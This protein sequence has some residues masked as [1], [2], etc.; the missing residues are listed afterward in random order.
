MRCSCKLE[1]LL[2]RIHFIFCFKNDRCNQRGVHLLDLEKETCL[3]PVDSQDAGRLN[4]LT[5]NFV[6]ECFY[7]AHRSFHLGFRVTVDKLVALNQVVNT[8]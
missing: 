8:H 6:T 1:L 3:V 5:F 4:A 2:K 7:M